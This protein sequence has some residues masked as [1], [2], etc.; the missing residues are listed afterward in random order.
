MYMPDTLGFSYLEILLENISMDLFTFFFA[1]ADLLQR[2]P[3]K[4]V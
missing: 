2:N 4:D 3:C 1:K